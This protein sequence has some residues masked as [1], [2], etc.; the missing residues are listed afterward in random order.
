MKKLLQVVLLTMFLA[1]FMAAQ[2]A[3]ISI[4]RPAEPNMLFDDDGG[5]VQVVPANL[6]PAAQKTFHGGAVMSSVQQ[7]S[8]F[9]GSGWSEAQV[10]S[11]Q[12]GLSD[13]GSSTAPELA[14]VRS[15]Q[16]RT[17]RA[18]PQVDDFSNVSSSPLNDL[19]IQRRLD[20]MLKSKAIPAPNAST[21]FVIFLAPGT[22]LTLGGTKAGVDFAAYHNIVHLDA[23]EVRYVVVPFDADA[24]KHAAA[25]AR[26]FAETALNP[27][28]QGWY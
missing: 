18:T 17:M 20:Q 13:V 23:G 25:A 8:I 24:Q 12:R 2:Q 7:V 16:I 9:L 3:P 15:R 11:R 5:K 1:Q 22:N 28:G 6:A 21:V 27:T 19:D 4:D 26:A 10:R 14:E